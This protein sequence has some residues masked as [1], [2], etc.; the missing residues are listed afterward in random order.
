[1]KKTIILFLFAA[2]LA[3]CGSGGGYYPDQ[4]LKTRGTAIV[5]QKGDEVYL[6]GF[7]IGN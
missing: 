3:G 4:F 6:Y 2:V 5:N 1:M 7:N